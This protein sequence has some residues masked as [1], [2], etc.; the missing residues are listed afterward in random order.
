MHNNFW[1][2]ALGIVTC[3]AVQQLLDDERMLADFARSLTKKLAPNWPTT[4]G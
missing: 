1:I 3:L 4:T 2:F